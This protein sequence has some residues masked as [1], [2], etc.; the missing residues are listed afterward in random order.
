MARRVHGTI[1]KEWPPTLTV[2]PDDIYRQYTSDQDPKKLFEKA[3]G[4]INDFQ[5][6]SDKDT[7]GQDEVIA[8]EIHE[9]MGRAIFGSNMIEHVGLGWD[10]TAQL[11]RRIF[12]GEDISSISE[13]NTA[14]Q[15]E[16]LDLYRQQ[17]T[18][19]DMPAQYVLRGRDEVVQHAKAFQHL[20][21]AFVVK[22]QGLTENLI[23]QTHQILTK[24]VPIVQPG[25]PDV[26]PED[27]GGIYR[28]VI[29][30]AGETNFTVPA[31]IPAKMEEMCARLAEELSIAESKNVIDPFSMAT[32]YSMEFV[33]I[34]R[35]RD[36]NGRMCRMILNAILCRYAGV[37][38]PIGEQEDDRDEYMG[39]KRRASQDMEG[40]GE[41]ATFAL[42]KAVTRLREMKK[43]LA[44]ERKRVRVD[45]RQ[46]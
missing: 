40:H 37:V 9:A 11:C 45:Q 43:K 10:I 22:K 42:K 12:A 28:T 2:R 15:D 46:T 20:L 7:C 1:A 6:A 35:F 13:R 29:V 36:G 44:R 38:I 4:W 41:Y 30:I 24:D 19:H 5:L 39:I 25:F 17:A 14:C 26:A 27:Y 8:K 16:L 32:K 31:S 33:Q 21:H 23:K 34:H 3:A 18:L